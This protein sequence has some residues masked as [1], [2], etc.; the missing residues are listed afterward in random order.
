MEAAINQLEKISADRRML[1]LYRARE[2][3]RLDEISKLKYAEKKGLEKGLEKGRQEGARKI[4]LNLL[5]Q[6]FAADRVAAITE[7]GL[8]EVKKLQE[9]L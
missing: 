3:A 1:E 6:G 5:K 2:K 8:E 4:A 9:E 7:L